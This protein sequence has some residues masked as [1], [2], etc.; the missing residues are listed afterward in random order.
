MVSPPSDEDLVAQIRKIILQAVKHDKLSELTKKSVRQ[1]L[2]SFFEVDL[3]DKKKFLNQEIQDAVNEA[4][5]ERSSTPEEQE[6]DDDSGRKAKVFDADKEE[7]ETP[8]K[9]RRKTLDHDQEVAKSELKTGKDVKGKAKKVLEPEEEEDDD[10]DGKEE[11]NQCDDSSKVNEPGIDCYSS[12]DENEAGAKRSPAK[13]TRKPSTG[14]VVKSKKTGTPASS[15][16]DVWEKKLAKLKSLV[17]ACGVRKQWK[18]LY[19]KEGIQ[20]DD[21]RMQCKYVDGVLEELG[22][23]SRRTMEQAKKIREKR[24][25]EDELAALQGNEIDFSG[26]RRSRRS[27]GARPIQ[28]NRDDEGLSGADEDED[29]N[30]D[31]GPRAKSNFKN[32]LASF[33][34]DLNDSDSE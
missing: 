7:V 4:A 21:Y 32:S 29:D 5:T 25:F 14:G 17:L 23:G 27:S 18:K 11:D 34:A 10:D 3:E 8:R 19:E 31:D 16:E 9:K 20:E 15:T 13:K 6:G 33:V 22:M 28:R 12:L 24:E 2:A 26:S 30:E 1:E